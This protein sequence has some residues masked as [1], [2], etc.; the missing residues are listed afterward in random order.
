MSLSDFKAMSWTSPDLIRLQ[1]NV[2]DISR[3]YQTSKQCHGHLQILSDFK[4]MSWTSPDLIRLQ[5]N[6]MDISR[7][8]K[9]RY[10]FIRLQSNVMDISRSVKIVLRLVFRISLFLDKCHSFPVFLFKIVL[11]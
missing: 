6:V 8:V 9:T 1:S 11:N 4:A 5:S 10:L 7:S 3:F 2:M